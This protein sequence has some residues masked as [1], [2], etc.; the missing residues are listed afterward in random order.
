M[1]ATMPDAES[2]AQTND[3]ST[4][5]GKDGHPLETVLPL[6]CT[7]GTLVVAPLSTVSNWEEQLATHIKEGVLSTYIYHGANREGSIDR[8]SQFDCIITTYTTLSQDFMRLKKNIDD[9]DNI[10]RLAASPL[11]HLKF[12]RIIL[13]EAHVIKD[14]STNQSIAACALNAQRRLCLTGTPLQNRLDD[15]AALVKFLRLA[16]FD[17]K[18]TWAHWIGGP[19]KAGN[20]AGL[21]RLQIITSATTLRR[22]K[23]QKID[24]K[25]ILDLPQKRE[26][27]RYIQMSASERQ[28]YE[29]TRKA[30]KNIVD[31]ITSAAHMREYVNILQAIMRL[32]QICC[33]RALLASEVP[34]QTDG[35]VNGGNSASDA[36]NV[37]EFDLQIKKPLTASQAYQLFDLMKEAGETTCVGCRRKDIAMPQ[38]TGEKEPS[39]QVL[40]YLTPCAH[41][42][43]HNCL[44]MY[45][46][47]IPNFVEGIVTSCPVCGSLAEMRMFELRERES[48]E[49]RRAGRKKFALDG[50]DGI[51]ASSKLQV[52]LDDLETLREQS[53]VA[54][55]PIKRYSDL[56]WFNASVIFSQWTSML[57]LMEIKL[58]KKG[59]G[60]SRLDGSMK[61]TDRTNAIVSFQND[62]KTVVMLVSIKAGGVGYFPCSS[63][64]SHVVST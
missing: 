23:A 31:N 47:Y 35:S 22:S 57:D 63:S 12:F 15:Y 62:A 46:M 7:K 5:T 44:E 18:H 42:L 6:K 4:R 8:L 10:G 48:V 64:I 33:H 37:D 11:H 19:L 34:T 40:G 52:L 2:F 49:V 41:P 43:C 60:Y 21:A 55:K 1:C 9:V 24:G 53:K 14:T 39:K 25:L 38:S 17:N 45:K 61:R 26:V 28:I 59:I 20:S 27:T 36:I 56:V 16:P 3:L 50:S 51:E 54:G 58:K 30:S 29:L 32:R 13:D